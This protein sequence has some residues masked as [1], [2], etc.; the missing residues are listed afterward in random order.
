MVWVSICNPL[1]NF[2]YYHNVWPI[3]FWFSLK[4]LSMELMLAVEVAH[5]GEPSRV[6]GPRK[7]EYDLCDNIGRMYGGILST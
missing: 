4:V 3:E 6:E 2:P 1:I 5:M 7:L